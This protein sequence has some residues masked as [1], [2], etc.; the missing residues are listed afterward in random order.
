MKKLVIIT[1]VIISLIFTAQSCEKTD[2][3]LPSTGLIGSGSTYDIQAKLYIYPSQ[4]IKYNDILSPRLY[5]KNLADNSVDGVIDIEDYWTRFSYNHFFSLEKPGSQASA[6]FQSNPLSSFS[7]DYNEKHDYTQFFVNIEYDKE[8]RFKSQK[9]CLIGS[10][11]SKVCNLRN[12]PGSNSNVIQN[13]EEEITDSNADDLID[14]MDI[15]FELNENCEIVKRNFV[16]DSAIESRGLID[17][18]VYL[19]QNGDQFTCE[20]ENEKDKSK[21]FVCRIED[22]VPRVSS[23]DKPQDEWIEGIFK[24]RCKLTLNSDLINFEKKEEEI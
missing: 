2:E 22:F 12:R 3:E 15:S 20:I 11:K 1:L 9:F 21:K 24:Y 16:S 6:R 17:Y 8:L 7:Y 4:R 10:T 19:S 23:E 14:K 18:Q 13:L 5:L